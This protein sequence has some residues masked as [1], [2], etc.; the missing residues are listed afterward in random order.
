VAQRLEHRADVEVLRGGITRHVEPAHRLG[1]RHVAF[2]GSSRGERPVEDADDHRPPA[3]AW[4][5]DDVRTILRQLAEFDLLVRGGRTSGTLD[6]RGHV[7][8][9]GQET[10][11]SG[12]GGTQQ[13]GSGRSHCDH[14]GGGRGEELYPRYRNGTPGDPKRRS[15]LRDGVHGVEHG[16][17]RLGRD[18]VR[19]QLEPELDSPVDRLLVHAE[20]SL[21]VVG[22]TASL[23][24]RRRAC[25][26]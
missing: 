10:A 5:R 1:I 2:T 21:E 14:H 26:A 18:Q 25:V 19:T 9:V 8:E 23:I 4:G 17:D 11:R 12:G 16:L 22:S 15:R 13:D 6:E 3:R 7:R 20:R 24:D